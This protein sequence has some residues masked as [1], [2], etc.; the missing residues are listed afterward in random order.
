MNRS[1][2]F[3]PD[4]TGD[5][6]V[7][8]VSGAS[9]L[10]EVLGRIEDERERVLILAHI[11]L[12]ISLRNLSYSLGTSATEIAERVNAIIMKLRE[13]ADLAMML[14]GISRAGRNENYQ[15]LVF[16]LGLQDW[17]CSYCGKFMVQSELGPL[18]RTCSGRCR[19]RLFR[20]NGVGWKDQYEGI[21][22]GLSQSTTDLVQSQPDITSYHEK[23]LRLIRTIDTAHKNADR[24]RYYGAFWQR[25][26]TLSRDRALL[27]LGF[28]CPTPLS[29][30]D[31]ATLDIDDIVKTKEGIEVRLYLRNL[32]KKRYINIAAANDPILCPA[33]AMSNWRLRLMQSGRTTGP[34]FIRMDSNGQLPRETIRLTDR[35]IVRII[36]NVFH[37]SEWW[38]FGSDQLKPSTPLSSIL[39]LTW[40][41]PWGYS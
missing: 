32:Q 16:R 23:V 10:E 35:D 34:L 40:P 38:S 17:F 1:R 22:A 21:P 33:V 15:A 5:A 14:S 20:A 4:S 24:R 7:G 13:D 11:G 28:M 39:E 36:I 19:N 9:L 29:P 12:D 31:I 18:R 3:A 6:A 8:N 27:L 37:Y 25:P 2:R 41:K 30:T 26:E